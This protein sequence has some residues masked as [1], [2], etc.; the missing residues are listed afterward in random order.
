[1]KYFG[2]HLIDASGGKLGAHG[3]AVSLQLLSIGIMGRRSV[4]ALD[5]MI[6]TGKA[7]ALNIM[8]AGLWVSS[9]MEQ[10]MVHELDYDPSDEDLMARRVWTWGFNYLQ[11]VTKAD[12]VDGV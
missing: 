9:I 8:I 11:R 7:W 3:I 1:M 6:R 10:P 5:L 2:L 4:S 12:P